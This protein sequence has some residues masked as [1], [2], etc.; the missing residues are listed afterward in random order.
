MT[1]VPDEAQRWTAT[2]TRC[3]ATSVMTSRLRNKA[4]P[5]GAR[6]PNDLTPA[7]RRLR[8]AAHPS[9]GAHASGGASQGG[10]GASRAHQRRDRA[11]CLFARLAAHVAGRGGEDRRRDAGGTGRVGELVYD[12]SLIHISEPT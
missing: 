11:Q 2:L 12:L 4:V 6:L 5:R 10:A 3:T 1:D 7:E 8:R 9:D